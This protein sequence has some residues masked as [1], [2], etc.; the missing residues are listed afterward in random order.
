[1]RQVGSM[2]KLELAERFAEYLRGRVERHAPSTNAMA[3]IASGYMTM[4]ASRRRKKN[5]RSS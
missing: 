5:C 1:M 4:T 3:A 2:S